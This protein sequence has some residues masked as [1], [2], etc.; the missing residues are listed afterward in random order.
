MTTINLH[1]VK[2][3]LS[4]YARLVKAGETIILCDR[5]KPFAEIRPLVVPTKPAS[6]RQ[7]GLMKGMCPMGPEFFAADEEVTR[8]F[9][10]SEIFPVTAALSLP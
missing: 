9:E 3:R 10:A 8:D 6:K 1:E 4:H 5:N 7:L 2:S